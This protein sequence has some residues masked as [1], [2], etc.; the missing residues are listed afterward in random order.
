VVFEQNNKAQQNWAEVLT[1][2]CW[3]FSEFVKPI[4]FEQKQLPD[5]LCSKI[6]STSADTSSTGLLV[7]NLVVSK[8]PVSLLFDAL[9]VIH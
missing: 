9:A 8:E 5:L 6:I 1:I 7:V 4:K 2:T 3:L